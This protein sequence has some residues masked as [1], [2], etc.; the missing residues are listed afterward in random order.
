MNVEIAAVITVANKLDILDNLLER[1]MTRAA[2]DT[3]SPALPLLEK[4]YRLGEYKRLAANLRVM[5]HR[6]R[7]ALGDE[8]TELIKS[9]ALGRCG[10]EHANKR[11]KIA[12]KKARKVLE[13]LG[14]Y[15]AELEKYK[16][17]PLYRAECNRLKRLEA[18]KR[19]PLIIAKAAVFATLAMTSTQS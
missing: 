11:V 5:E 18:K 7:S 19:E 13:D 14:V 8:N 12:Y 1:R 16:A 4:V 15:A 17:L 3:A 6:V 9:A 10:L 2:L